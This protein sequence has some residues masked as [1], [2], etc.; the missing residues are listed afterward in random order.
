M[1]DVDPGKAGALDLAEQRPRVLRLEPERRE[2]Q[3]LVDVAQAERSGLALVQR[4]AQRG[5]E[6]GADEADGVA[7]RLAVCLS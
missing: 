4:G 6:L 3:A 2:V 1:G 7:P 5:V